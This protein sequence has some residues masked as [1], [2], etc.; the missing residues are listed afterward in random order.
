MNESYAII[1]EFIQGSEPTLNEEVAFDIG[2]NIGK[3]S[4]LNIPND[5]IRELNYIY[6]ME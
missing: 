1:Y 2:Q 5:T 3:L 6:S 4:L